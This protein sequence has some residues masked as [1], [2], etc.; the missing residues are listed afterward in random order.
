MLSLKWRK[1][2]PKRLTNTKYCMCINNLVDLETIWED[3]TVIVTL[4]MRIIK[5]AKSEIIGMNIQSYS[6]TQFYNTLFNFLLCTTIS[7]IIYII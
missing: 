3:V 4:N 2:H 1:T 5:V 6:L 7:N